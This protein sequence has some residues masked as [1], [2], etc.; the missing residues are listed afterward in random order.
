MA[1][2]VIGYPLSVNYCPS[3]GSSNIQSRDL[4]HQDGLMKCDDCEVNCYIIEGE[5]EVK[6]G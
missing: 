6:E 5:E 4:W 1:T 2:S 3:C